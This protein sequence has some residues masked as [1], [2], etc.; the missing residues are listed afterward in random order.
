MRN[1]GRTISG[2]TVVISGGAS[3][4]GRVLAQRLSTHGCPVAITDID[5]RGLKVLSRF[6]SALRRRS[7]QRAVS[8]V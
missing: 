6:E 8:A 7:R 1:S 5:E 4:I 3:G 2:R